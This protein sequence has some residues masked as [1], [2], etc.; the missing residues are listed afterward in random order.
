MLPGPERRLRLCDRP[1]S[2]SAQPSKKAQPLRVP[3]NARP[4]RLQHLRRFHRQQRQPPA[5]APPPRR[6]SG[7]YPLPAAP[8]TTIRIP[9]PAAPG[10]T[11]SSQRCHFL[12]RPVRQRLPS[13]LQPRRFHQ[14]LIQ[15]CLP[16]QPFSNLRIALQR[17]RLAGLVLAPAQQLPP[18]NR[19][20]RQ[21]TPGLA[22]A[23]KVAPPPAPAS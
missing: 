18:K 23:R 10:S 12:H 13:R 17:R 11:S 7:E 21:T 16:A 3:V 8:I 14:Q 22:H 20:L 4:L 15:R 6:T 9:S 1:P 2:R 5:R 19:R